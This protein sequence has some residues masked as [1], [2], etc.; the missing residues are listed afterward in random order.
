MKRKAFLVTL[1]F[2]GGVVGRFAAMAGARSKRWPGD[3][4]E[5][6]SLTQAVHQHHIWPGSS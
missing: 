1:S 4:I 5:G 6:P 2:R 3:D